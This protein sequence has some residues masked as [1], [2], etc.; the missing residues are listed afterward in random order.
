MTDERS[1]AQQTARQL[2]MAAADLFAV[3]DVTL[4]IPGQP[5]TIRFRGRLRG[6]SEEAFPQIL[7][8]YR[9]IGNTALL[10]EDQDPGRHILLAVPGV[11]PQQTQSRLWLNALLDL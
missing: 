1:T 10:R 7:A 9:V 2:E 4:G 11:E 5:E 6:P 8:R 3:G